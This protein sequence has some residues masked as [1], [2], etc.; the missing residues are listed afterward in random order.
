MNR[1]VV[2]ALM[3]IAGFFLISCSNPGHKEREEDGEEDTAV[4]EPEA[5]DQQDGDI[6]REEIDWE[7]FAITG[8]EPDHGPFIGGTQV[9]VRGRGFKEGAAVYFGEHLVEPV[10]TLV[11]DDNRL[12]VLSPAGAP[13]TVDVRVELEG[14][15]ALK[16]D[17]FTYD[18]FYV[19]PVSGSVAGG[20]V[21]AI[22]GSGTEFEPAPTVTFDGEEAAEVNWISTTRITCRTPPGVVGPADVR[23]RGDA[24]DYEVDE[25]YVY[26]NSADPINGGL[27]GGRI[28]GALNVTVLD[29]YTS[30]PVP[31]AFC[32]L[33]VSGETT[34][35]GLTDDR[36]Q[37]TFSHADLAGPQSLTCGKEKYESTTIREFDAR[38]V[39]IFLVPIPDPEP[40]PLPPGTLGAII[41]G[42]LVFE[43]GG[44]FGPG[45][46]EIV[47]D[48]GPNEQ[49]IAYVYATGYSI[50]YPPPSPGLSGADPIV[51]EDMTNTGD[52][53]FKFSVFARPET[54]AVWA[55]AGILNTDTSAF[56]P[57]AFGVARGI[58]AG[59]GE[60]VEGVLVY[61]VHSLD[62]SITVEM[63]PY[64]PELE[65]SY[66]PTIYKSDLYID[67]GG[68]GVIFRDDATQLKTD[69]SPFFYPGW[70]P[71]RYELADAS[72]T[73]VVGA[74]TPM[75]DALTG[76]TVYAN[77]FT[78]KV[79]DNLTRPDEPIV[80]QDF[81]GVPYP[82]D[83]AYGTRITGM[84]MEF[85][86]DGAT[87][88]FWLAMLQTYPDQLPL[89]RI[90]IPGDQLSYELPD[91]AAIAS[92]PAPPSGYTVWIVYGISSPGFVY[93]EFTYRYLSQSYWS[94]FSADAFIFEF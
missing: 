80:A 6:E 30:E 24:N 13:G 61:M 53:G 12:G 83:P 9:V 27:G 84:R 35:Q 29:S 90:L 74:Y 89:W 56:V 7:E 26:F 76:Q 21:V 18:I 47:P 91:L 72:Y 54:V 25:A 43:H 45:P 4:G 68:D 69:A 15:T 38:D 62:Q 39:T 50:W 60:E 16:E 87:P 10:Y 81:I 88:D 82:I 70:L 78:V 75:I 40:G 14:D 33:G 55:L 64:F 23:V 52:H 73:A 65:L 66:G 41:H 77:P 37:I 11:I 48:P 17:A 94:A 3:I 19:D 42:E 22:E 67:L 36:G 46:W 59:P 28:E 34:D 58:V 93:N 63:E 86:N 31:E 5:P 49:K 51:E 57:Y 44:E 85:G 32:I 92:L 1:S 20:T 8:V 2:I 71:L 79:L